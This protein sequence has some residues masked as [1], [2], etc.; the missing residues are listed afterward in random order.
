MIDSHAHLFNEYYDDIQ[1]VL[2]RAKENGIEYV[3]N[4][5]DTIESCKEV[6]KHAEEYDNYYFCWKYYRT[7]GRPSC[8]GN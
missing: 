3:V 6:I 1:A 5:A 4:A 8:I 2:D 7:A